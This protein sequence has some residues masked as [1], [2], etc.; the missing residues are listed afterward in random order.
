M[1]KVTIFFDLEGQY[2]T[3]A[4]FDSEENTGKIL[5]ILDQFQI[6]SVFNVCGALA[7]RSP[8]LVRKIH[9]NAHEISSHGYAHEDFS[10][11]NADNIYELLGRT[12]KI[13]EKITGEKPTGL[14]PP[15]LK[16][17]K[18]L[19]SIVDKRGYTWV[20]SSYVP[21]HE[22]TLRP[23]AHYPTYSTR[24]IKALSCI[25]D[26]SKK[27]VVKALAAFYQKE[28]FRPFESRKLYEVPLLSTMD[29]NLLGSMLPNEK[30]SISLLKFAYETLKR[31]FNKSKNYFNLNFHVWLIG[32]SNR[33][34]LLEKILSYISKQEVEFL[35]A[36]QL[37]E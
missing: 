35:L 13:L 33:P 18:E 20:S 24:K 19:Y 23:R 37:V 26:Q 9:D 25:Q 3:H 27:L 14:R 15:W 12:E 32:S 16:R 36:R 1:K 10:Q 6:R 31:Q 34:C 8:W 7:E 4:K 11:L 2:G 22:H 5:S 21:Q 30:S 29:Y 17:G 28:P